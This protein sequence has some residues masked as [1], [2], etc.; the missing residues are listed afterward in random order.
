M[1]GI[2]YQPVCGNYRRIYNQ[3]DDMSVSEHVDGPLFYG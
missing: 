3:A 1:Y 2:S